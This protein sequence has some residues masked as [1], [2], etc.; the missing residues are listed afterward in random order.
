MRHSLPSGHS[1]AH[2]VIG[3]LASRWSPSIV[4]LLRDGPKRYSELRS[5]IAGVSEKMLAQTLRELERDGLVRRTSY[6]V[7]P[8]HVVYALTP[9]GGDCAQHV[10]VLVGWLQ[11]NVAEFERAQRAYDA[12][13]SPETV[14]V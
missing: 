10:S 1:I 7:L 2:V 6:P 13:T 14:A 3:H 4:C 12:E 5:Q 8:R 9:L 11:A